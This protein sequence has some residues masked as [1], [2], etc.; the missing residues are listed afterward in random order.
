MTTPGNRFQITNV[1]L[2][3]SY[4]QSRTRLCGVAPTKARPS[5][6]H[7]LGVVQC[8]ASPEIRGKIWLVRPYEFCAAS[9]R[10]SLITLVHP[11][12]IGR[13]CSRSIIALRSRRE[14]TLLRTPR[15]TRRA[16]RTDHPGAD[17]SSRWILRSSRPLQREGPL[18]LL[19]DPSRFLSH[20]SGSPS[21]RRFQHQD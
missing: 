7:C 15:T 18:G 5:L 17:R 10:T 4:P 1:H 3:G 14:R 13:E 19:Q 16:F 11:D 12:R 2:S 9:F 21:Q 6:C 20:F 8:L